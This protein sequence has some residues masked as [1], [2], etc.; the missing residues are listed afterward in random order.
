[1]QPTE[2]DMIAAKFDKEVNEERRD[3]MEK[4]LKK[5]EDEF[6]E[7]YCPCHNQKNEDTIC[8]CRYLRD[9]NVCRCGL[10]VNK[11]GDQ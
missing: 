8:P 1:M 10:F 5:M 11:R 9:Y 4:K 6:G 7:R 3:L 2:I